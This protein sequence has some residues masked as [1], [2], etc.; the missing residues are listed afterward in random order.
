MKT[1]IE[2]IGLLGLAWAGVFGAAVFLAVSTLY[3]STQFNGIAD[4]QEIIVNS[5]NPVEIKKIHVV[6]GQSVIPGQLLVE[7]DN[8]EITLKINQISHRIDQL[9]AQ[10]HVDKSAL[11]SKI[12]Q[13]AAEKTALT[14]ETAHRIQELENTYAINQSLASGLKS[15]TL[16][17]PDRVDENSHPILLQIE[18]LRQDLAM[19]VKPLDIEMAQLT[20]ALTDNDNPALILVNQLEKELAVLVRENGKLNIYSPISGVIGSVNYKAAEK[21]APFSPIVTLH[22]KTPAVIKGYIRENEY[23]RVAVGDALSVISQT[24]ARSRVAGAVV[25]VGARIVEFPE[26]LRKHPDLH[27]WGR[28]VTVRI[29]E[30]NGLILGEK[31]MLTI[32]GRRSSVWDEVKAAVFPSDT[33]AES[34]SSHD[35]TAV[36]ASGPEIFPVTSSEQTGIEASA[37]L[38]L[39]DIDRYLVASDD[40]PEKSGLLYLMTPSG[41]ITGETPIA[42]LKVMDDMESMTMDENGLIYIAA[43]L[44]QNKKGETPKSRRLLV[45]IKRKKEMLFLDRRMDLLAVLSGCAGN[46]PEA[47]WAAF[48]QE[49]LRSGEI[50]IEGMFF[51]NQ[52]LF[53]GFKSPLSA[54]R[55]VILKLDGIARLME[56][57]EPAPG[58]VSIWKMPRLTMGDSGAPERISDLFY[59]KGILYLTGVSPD[60]PDG[61]VAGSLWRI[62]PEDGDLTRLAH[63]K[64][65]KPEGIALTKEQGAVMICF[66]QGRRYQSQLAVIRGVQ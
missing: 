12:A 61:D 36:Q 50:D 59:Q 5:E 47:D 62:N 42:G 60:S 14:G 46:S 48:I 43:S 40:T 19:K 54:G 37:L 8:P 57:R 31:V 29:P 15:V 26:R 38:Y 49:G 7:L 20:Q 63:F 24:G 45:T 28:E 2:G 32:D 64:D 65:L 10:K 23:T 17:Y 9:K 52:A 27:I 18:G 25:G 56:G 39:A 16:D 33:L 35:K 53:L 55:S 58:Q 21:A 66:D 4:T 44:S 1:R 6:E 13:L 22:T 41:Q 3:E 30:A 34:P 11:E 51:D